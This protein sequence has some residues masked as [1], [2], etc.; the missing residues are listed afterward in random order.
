MIE[1]NTKIPRSQ[2]IDNN[3]T[4]KAKATSYRHEMTTEV[5]NQGTGVKSALG[6][7]CMIPKMVS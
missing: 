1:K 2:M 3:M 6:P 4:C 5:N 7:N